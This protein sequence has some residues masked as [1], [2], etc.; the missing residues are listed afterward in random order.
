[1]SRRLLPL[2]LV[3]TLGLAACGGDDAG[4]TAARDATP[5]PDAT[6]DG[7]TTTPAPDD[8]EGGGGPEGDATP[9]PGGGSGGDPQATPAPVEPAPEGRLNRPRAGRYLYDLEGSRSGPGTV[10]EQPYGDGARVT[11][12]VSAEGDVYTARS[13][14][15]QEQG[16]TTNRTRF[17]A[18]GVLLEY[19]RLDSPFASFECTYT[20]PVRILRYPLK[21]ETYPAQE[22]SNSDCSGSVDI[23]VTGQAEIQAAGRTWTTW[24]VESVTDYRFGTSVEG[25]MEGTTWYAPDLGTAV[26]NDMRNQ[27]T[28]TSTGSSQSFSSHQVTTLLQHP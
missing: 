16:A 14:T 20:P 8:G 7:D 1:M 12:D 26:R 18:E 25:R 27:G 6:D 11:I 9:A 22:W 10:S 3:L 21:A 4:P 13:S 2:L 28:F 23:R 24:V 17:D 5:T 19:T 15:N